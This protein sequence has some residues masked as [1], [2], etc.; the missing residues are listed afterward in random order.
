MWNHNVGNYLAPI[1][2]K[3][4]CPAFALG[5]RCY[6][7]CGLTGRAGGAAFLKIEY[8]GSYIEVTYRVIYRVINIGVIY[9]VINIGVIYRGCLGTMEKKLETTI[10]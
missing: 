1:L 9:M 4:S 8:I 10:L 3:S 6:S 7:R 5:E 2:R